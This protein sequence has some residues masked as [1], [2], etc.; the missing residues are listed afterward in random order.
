MSGL[1]DLFAV[2]DPPMKGANSASTRVSLNA[3]HEVFNGHFPDR[4]ILPGV[5]MVYI[6]TRII[7]T[8]TGDMMRI[9][10]ARAI[11]FLAPVDPRAT[12]ELTFATTL[13][14]SEGGTRAEVQ[15]T[16]GDTVVMKLIA[17]VVRDDR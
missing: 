7:S 3:G 6:A 2:I 12:P 4:P 9:D 14:P 5:V 8:M 10:Q 11:K 1:D 17:S 15:A 13:Q 16:A